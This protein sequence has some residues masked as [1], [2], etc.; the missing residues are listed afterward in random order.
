MELF[1]G[2]LQNRAFAL[3][4][5]E[6]GLG[7]ATSVGDKTF[8]GAWVDWERFLKERYA[9]YA[10]KYGLSQEPRSGAK[11]QASLGLLAAGILPDRKVM[12]L[13]LE[14]TI[15]YVDKLRQLERVSTTED[16]SFFR[17]VVEQEEA[18]VES[19]RFRANGE[20]QSAADVLR[21][22]MEGASADKGR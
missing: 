15:S 5:A 20:H 3:L 6:R 16:R 10:K 22:F 1:D 17:F 12:N 18:Q 9:P 4:S 2:E 11:M 8:L 14:Q 7:N 21:N 19:L 13:M